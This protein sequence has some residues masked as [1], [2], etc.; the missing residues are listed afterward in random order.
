MVR[1]LLY[2]PD[3]NHARAL[4]SA[5]ESNHYRLTVCASRRE[6]FNYLTAKPPQFKVVILDFSNR[7]EDWEFLDSVRTLTVASV[8]KP[9]LLCLA[10]TNWGPEVKLKMERKGARLVYERSA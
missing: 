6:A 5:L 1:I 2:D 8:P 10:R 3:Q 7:P 9:G 4:V